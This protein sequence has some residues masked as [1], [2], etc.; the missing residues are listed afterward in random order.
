RCTVEL[1]R[2]GQDLALPSLTC[3]NVWPQAEPFYGIDG[4]VRQR[5]R[6]AALQHHAHL[7]PRASLFDQSEQLVPEPDVLL[8]FGGRMPRDGAADDEYRI[9][10]LADFRRLCRRNRKCAR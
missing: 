5:S 2:I 7:A 4:E 3:C 6:A 8:L 9:H 1:C 10:P